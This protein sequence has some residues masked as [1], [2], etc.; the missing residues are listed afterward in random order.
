MADVV[1]AGVDPAVHFCTYGWRE[2]RRPN[3]YFD[4]GWYLDTHA[5]PDGMNP[6]THYVL[7]GENKGLAPSQ[8]FNPVWY[9]Q[10]YAI[11]PTVSALAHFLAHRRTGEVSPVP[12][13]DVAAY[14]QAHE[15]TLLPHRDPYAHFLATGRFAGEGGRRAAA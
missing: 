10:R 2:R 14:G 9:R 4:T 15:A 8:H 11:A 3:A 7:L 6:L 5:V 13:F 12:S 1:A